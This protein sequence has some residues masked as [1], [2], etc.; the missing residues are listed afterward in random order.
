MERRD[1]KQ[2]GDIFDLVSFMFLCFILSSSTIHLFLLSC[3]LSFLHASHPTP[4][5]FIVIFFSKS[6]SKTLISTVTIRVFTWLVLVHVTKRAVSMGS[7]LVARWAPKQM[8]T[9]LPVGSGTE[10]SYW[11]I[12]SLSLSEQQDSSFFSLTSIKQ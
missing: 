7:N 10:H 5:L 8:H 3:F 4:S 12:S 1:E 11:L 9:L 2:A 6:P